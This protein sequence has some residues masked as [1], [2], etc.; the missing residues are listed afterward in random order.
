MS[1]YIADI[2]LV[3]FA[4]PELLWLLAGLPVLWFRFHDRRRVVAQHWRLAVLHVH[5]EP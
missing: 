2:L 5:G 1:D 4:K 3:Q